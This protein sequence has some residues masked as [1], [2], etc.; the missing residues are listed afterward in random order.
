LSNEAKRPTQNGARRF[1]AGTEASLP[2]VNA[3]TIEQRSTAPSQPLIRDKSV[4]P[5]R[6]WRAVA[7]HMPDH[8]LRHWRARADS[9]LAFAVFE[10]PYPEHDRMIAGWQ[11]EAIEAELAARKRRQNLPTET[12]AG[13][14]DSFI[15]DL[16]L[17]LPL[18][19]L[20]S[21]GGDA[22]RKVGKEY[23]GNC[24]FHESKSRTSLTVSSDKGVWHCHGCGK[25]GDAF[26]WICERWNV[27]F[28]DAVR[29]LAAL[30][31][32]EIPKELTLTQS[33]RPI[34]RRSVTR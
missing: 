33:R 13:F 7:R 16:K 34:Y 15:A 29:I 2:A 12:T 19:D 24:P 3:P 21:R 28:P 4:D 5:V 14:S 27:E 25:G 10:S 23:R 1:T 17:R 30:I 31:G 11:I 18:H 20:I 22:L 6:T 9:V 26:T 8:D 32:V